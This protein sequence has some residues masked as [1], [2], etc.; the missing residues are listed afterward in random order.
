MPKLGSRDFFREEVDRARQLSEGEKIQA[1]IELFELACEMAMG[2]IRSK[3][4]AANDEELLEKLR[5][6]LTLARSLE[7]GR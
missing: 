3:N 5:E 6:R 2:D 4:P 7:D 1:S